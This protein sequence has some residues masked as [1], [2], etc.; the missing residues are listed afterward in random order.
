MLLQVLNTHT[1]KHFFAHHLSFH[2]SSSAQRKVMY[3]K[4]LSIFRQISS[5]YEPIKDTPP[6]GKLPI[7]FAVSSNQISLN[8]CLVA[9]SCPSLLGSRGLYPAGSSVH[10]IFQARILERD[11][12]SFSRESSQ[13]RVSNPCL[14]HCRILHPLTYRGGLQTA[15]QRENVMSETSQWGLLWWWNK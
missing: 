6:S 15:L 9:K 7:Q 5:F 13:T 11:A 10:R 12:I 1:Q 8:M 14:L 2:A 4:D 3:W